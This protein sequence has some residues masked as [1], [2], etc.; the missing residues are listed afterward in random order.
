MRFLIF[1]YGKSRMKRTQLVSDKRAECHILLPKDDFSLER[2]V[3]LQFKN[4]SGEW[5]IK[6]TDC[7]H[8]KTEEFFQMGKRKSDEGI[9]YKLSIGRKNELS[10]GGKDLYIQL[11]RYRNDWSIYKKYKL[12][13]CRIIKEKNIFIMMEKAINRK[14]SMGIS[15]EY[16]K[17]FIEKCGNIEIY[18]NEIL[19]EKKQQLEFGDVI[20]LG[21]IYLLFFENYIAVE[22]GERNIVSDYLEE[23][24]L[25]NEIK[26]QEDVR[27]KEKR[28]ITFHRAP[29]VMEELKKVSLKVDAPPQVD[30]QEKKSIFMDIGTIMNL[31]FPMLGMNLFL[32]YGMK[33][34]QNQAGIYVYSGLFMA[35]M[36]AVCSILW[37]MIS[38]KYE[39]REQQKKVNKERLAYRRYLNKKSEYIKVQYERV[40]KVLQSRYLRA[41]TYLDSPL[42]DMY[43]WN[44]NLY[45]KDFLMYRIGIGDVEF[46]MK[47]EFPEEVFGDEE[48]ILWREAKKIKEH[49]EI[50]H[51]I[52]VLLDM[53]RY[54][55]IGIITKDT[56]AGMELVRSIILQIALCN[57]YTE[58]KIGCIYNK[59]KVIQSQQWDF[60]RWLPHIWDANRQKRFIA[61]N[62]VEARRL[63]YDLLQIFKE[64]EEVSISGKAEKILP[65]YILFVAEEQFL[66]G[67]MF[68]KYILDRG[69]EYGLTVVWLDSMRKKLPNTCKMV[70]EING[71]FTGRYEIE[72]H[73][74]KKEKI[75]FD[76]TEKNIAEKLIRSISGIKVMEIEEKAGIPEVVDFLGMYDVHTIEEL[77]IKQRWEKNRI[78]E[79]AKVLI[80]KK[81]GDEPFYLDIHERYHGPHGLLAGTTGSGKSEVLQT[82]ILS[83][84]VNFS[85]EAVCFLL[86]DYKGEGMSA[87]FSELPHI[88]GK[89][90]NLSDG[91]A[92]RAMVSIKSENK[93]RQ[94]IFKECK[95][96]NI[97]DYTRL[98]N[99]GSVNEPIPH[100]L[101]IID[102]FAELKKAEPEFMQELISVAQVGRSLGVHLLLATQK[103]GGV[104]DDKIWS[105]SRFRI[106]LKVQEREDSMDMLHNMDACQI[107]QTGRGYL[108]VGNNEVYELFQ[109]GWSGALFQQ[110]DTEVAACLVQ[111]DGTIYY[112][113]AA[114][115]TQLAIDED[116][117]VMD[118]TAGDIGE[119]SPKLYLESKGWIGGTGE[120]AQY[121][122]SKDNR[123]FT[124]GVEENTFHS[125]LE[126][127]SFL[128][129]VSEK[130]SGIDQEGFNKVRQ[131]EQGEFERKASDNPIYQKT[132]SF[133]TEKNR[134][135]VYSLYLEYINR[136]GMPLIGDKGAVENYGN[137]LSGTFK[138]KK[139]V[140]DKKCPEIAGLKLEKADKKK[141]GIRFAKKS[142]SETY[143]T[144]EIYNTDKKCDTDTTY[145]IDEECYY[146]TSVKGMIDIREKYLDLD[147]IHIQAMPLDD[148]AREA[149]KENEAESNDGM[150]DILAWTHTKKG[151]LHQISFDFA[152]EGK[153][154]FILD[155]A[156]L[157]GNKGVSNQTGEEGIES[158]D[159]TIDKSAPELSVDYKGIIN[160]MEAESSPAN[161]NKKLKSNGEKITSSGNELFMK[162]ENS[163]DICIEDMNLEAEN[164]EL[165]LYRVKYGL[166][167]KIEQN[168]ES[169]EEITEKIKQEPEKQ[170]LEKGEQEKNSKTVMRYSVTNLDDGHYKLMIHCT[171]K[172]GN[173]MTAEKSSE[174]ERC[175]YNGYYESPLYTVDTK[176]PLI[177]SVILNQN[178]VKKIGK[179]QYFQ[180]APQITIKIQE[181]NFNKI[182]FSLEGK[183]F[184]S[185]GMVMEKE[186]ERF[187]SQEKSLQ[188]K[189][190]YEDGIRINET[191][192]QVEA[193]GNYTLNFGVIDSAACVANQENLKITYDCHKPE[194]IYTGVDNESGDL[195]F[196]AEENGD[197]KKKNTLLLF[198]KYH[199]FRYFSKR[200][201]N[202]F[203]RIKDAISG[204]ERINYAFIPYEEQTID[205]NKFSQVERTGA[206]KINDEYFEKKDLSEFSIT[207]SPEKENFKGYLKVYGQDYS[208]NVSE[209][210]KSKGAISESLQLHKETSNIT[211]KMPRAFFTDKEKNIRYYNSTVPVQA[212]FED[213]YAG[214][215]KTQLYAKTTKKKD[216]SIKTGKTIM[217]DGDNLI[218]RKRQQIEL[219]ADKF[220]QSDADNPLTIQADLEDNAGHT[221]KNILNEKVVIDNTK[222]EIE[223][224]YNQNN[225]TQYYNF[226]RKATVT[227]KEKNFSPDLVVWNI[228]GSNQKYQI[229]EWK[230]VQGTYVCE[231]SFEEDGR[232]YSVGLSVTD[233]AGNKSEWKDRNY[234]TI[235]KTVPQ[236]S[237][238]I[239]GIGKQADQVPYFNTERIITFCIQEQNFDKDKVEYNIDAIHGKSRITI[240]KPVKYQEDGDKYYSRLV[241]RKEAK[242]HIQVK[243]TD[244]AGN[245]SETA[246][247][248]EFI[249][250]TTTP[251]VHIAGVKQNG[252]Y[253]GK[254]IMPQVICKDQYLDRESVEISLKKIDDRNVL[255]KE[256]SYERAESENTVQVQWDN[257]KKTENSDGIYYLQIKGQDK[258]GNKIK[259]DFK[260]VFCVNQRGA[261]F[262]LSHALK[263]KINKYYL[264][265]A[266]KIKLRE[267][268]VK[269]TKSRAVILKDNEERKVIGESSITSS[270]IADKKSERYGWYE[271][272]YNFAKKDFEREGDYRVTFQADTKEKELRFVVDK[273]P[274]VVHI[275]N[276]DKQI[277]EEK[278]HEFTIRVMDNYAFKEL[279][280]YME[281]D[282]N[283]LGQ[284]GTKKIII[285]PKDLDEN[286][287][288][289]KT[290]TA[291]KRY[292]TVR[293]I[294]RDKAGNVIDSNDNGDTKVCLVTDSK[295]VKE[296]QEHK[297]EYMLIGIISTLGIFI[298]I[299][300]SGLFIFTRRKRNLK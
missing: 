80:G 2:T 28:E 76:Y 264:K 294:A 139:L 119:K 145:N 47:I 156:D 283:I 64:R 151:N 99:S 288:V 252:I 128:F 111:T 239:N 11:I 265:E 293:Y 167:G 122:F 203:I 6:E 72:R 131:Y 148:R 284:K 241:L 249:I 137:I 243:C 74:Q 31:M 202:V 187:K 240:K 297:K 58:V 256:W 248:K 272:Y 153:W 217:W 147:S 102:E 201:M 181:E 29:R 177:T 53:G 154:K 133:E 126:K 66:E 93:R 165:K 152:V 84:A 86:I 162:R 242:Y 160:V 129:Q 136:W 12:R 207:V 257:I 290:L 196:K 259:D 169:W 14:N 232:D 200:R 273:T 216:S 20:C 114:V 42:L 10:V 237:I 37:L 226:S 59:N 218:Y 123:T 7:C 130:E 206:E 127:E 275:G 41:D 286:Y 141:E 170:E 62:E 24:V 186:W 253:Q 18:I 110:E 215:Y 61:G 140:I 112:V 271:K 287:M 69:R 231:I 77:H 97:N 75:N 255:K 235:D 208:G 132:L 16:G 220:S 295:T 70:L 43:L 223:V 117:E 171:D 222:P 8:L 262:I 34:E 73:S 198:H 51:Q 227:V 195:I 296:Y 39:K 94:R 79:S 81:A 158:T 192:I 107:T 197:D 155:C 46:P 54:S 161:I 214:I 89:I 108:Q 234:F 71:G 157:A 163:I 230:N 9:F 228:Q 233:K 164:I 176:S 95:V 213:T 219:E 178:A 101:I 138:S 254:K 209:M 274:P 142:V 55:Q 15:Y 190:Y 204:I 146:N 60:C 92:Y 285:K 124:I 143:N 266:P 52:P 278:E 27:K 263:K 82:F 109:A 50:L 300:G 98:F 179:R 268:C 26:G 175:I 144:D 87:L 19:L 135:K 244:K 57:C 199:F 188:W 184:Y 191:N 90:S 56:I 105:N 22:A 210:V 281:T 261:D 221:E 224:V 267:Q 106:C 172:A 245:V 100:L 269:Q 45:H 298:V 225:Q 85:P 229:G 13:D 17:W 96:N 38:R 32:I 258:A 65:H 30:V 189:S 118:N 44:R 113:E 104:V 280:L 25:E 289:R 1:I 193:E 251:A 21:T 83:M 246:E 250:D 185:N 212:I 183:M 166:N 91:Q 134:H 182:N 236:I 103:P 194:I 35:V 238:Q 270:V 49:Y 292:Q 115:I 180:N 282:R 48:N 40:Y 120:F 260:V 277:Y 121:L 173:V 5:F 3:F 205:I 276:L 159:V 125:D 63:F 78:F 291:D 4:I 150:L 299:S 149:V 211:M 67:E 279:E 168:K 23:V 88:S 33:S 68:S 174:T 247:T 36:S 116:T